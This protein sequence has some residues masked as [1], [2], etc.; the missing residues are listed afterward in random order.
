MSG[1]EGGSVKTERTGRPPC[2]SEHAG[3]TS[4]LKRRTTVA[5]VSFVNVSPSYC[6]HGTLFFF[7]PL[8]LG[9]LVF[10]SCRVLDFLTLVASRGQVLA[11]GSEGRRSLY[12]VLASLFCLSVALSP[13]VAVLSFGGQGESCW[14]N[15][16]EV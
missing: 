16:Q 10:A 13:L 14:N 9:V 11:L 1:G 2:R 15:A 6:L 3:R 4:L 12:G 5:R 7:A 8:F